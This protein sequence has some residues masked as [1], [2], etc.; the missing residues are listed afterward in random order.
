[1]GPI[2]VR[3]A[4]LYLIVESWCFVEGW[5]ALTIVYIYLWLQSVIISTDKFQS[6]IPPPEQSRE[7]PGSEGSVGVE[8]GG[9][10]HQQNAGSVHHVAVRWLYDPAELD[11]LA[12]LLC[13][14]YH[15][16]V[17]RYWHPD[18]NHS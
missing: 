5:G 18:R 17:A 10:A 9:E 3:Q 13:E 7:R 11:P 12:L 2:S 4:R 6:G 15:L 16:L 1:M 8:A 14:P